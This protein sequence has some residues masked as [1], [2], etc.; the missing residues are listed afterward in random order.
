MRS[1]VLEAVVALSAGDAIA[2]GS[3][4]QTTPEPIWAR[5]AP[6]PTGFNPGEA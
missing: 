2:A 5:N 6:L 3:A 1:A 4:V